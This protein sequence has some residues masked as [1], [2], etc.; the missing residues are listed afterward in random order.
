MV[1]ERA[2]LVRT[3]KICHG[4]EVMKVNWVRKAKVLKVDQQLSKS[5]R[6]TCMQDQLHFPRWKLQAVCIDVTVNMRLT[7]TSTLL[8]KMQFKG[9]IYF[10]SCKKGL[11]CTLTRCCKHTVRNVQGK[12]WFW[13]EL[14]FSSRVRLFPTG[15]IRIKNFFSCSSTSNRP[16][17]AP[18]RTLLGLWCPRLSYAVQRYTDPA[19]HNARIHQRRRHCDDIAN[20]WWLCSSVRA[21]FFSLLQQTL[22]QSHISRYQI[23]SFMLYIH[24]LVILHNI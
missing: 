2:C 11:S 7:M 3:E 20:T 9:A 8:M 24:F 10:N 19:M 17:L 6:R 23:H 5:I 18:S 15:L 12:C 22:I 4:K 16:L 14:R 21:G 1:L 13:S